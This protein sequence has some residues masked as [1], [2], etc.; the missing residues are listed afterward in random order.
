[1]DGSYSDY[2]KICNNINVQLY[3]SL[4]YKVIGRMLKCVYPCG[5]K[6]SIYVT[7]L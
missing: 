2:W 7:T 5:Y 3:N 1:M 6:G 4:L